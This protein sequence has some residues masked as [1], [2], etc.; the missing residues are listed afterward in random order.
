MN[1]VYEYILK[2]CS[3]CGVIICSVNMLD[4]ETTFLTLMGAGPPPSLQRV[5]MHTPAGRVGKVLPI[6]YFILD[7]GSE[8]ATTGSQE[9]ESESETDR[10]TTTPQT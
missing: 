10:A 4:C 7:P 8:S 5:G 1:T 2:F 3:A 9:S 6:L